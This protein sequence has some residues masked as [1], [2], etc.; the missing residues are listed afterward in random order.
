M[1]DILVYEVM[2]I[3]PIITNDQFFVKNMKCGLAATKDLT[4]FARETASMQENNAKVSSVCCVLFMTNL[5]R[6]MMM[7]AYTKISRQLG[8]NTQ[9]SWSPI[10]T[11]LI[12]YFT[13]R[14]QLCDTI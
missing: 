4:D 2:H 12:I 13:K 7:Q 8:S 14:T 5:P 9:V 6:L 10:L 3:I 1:R 11:Y